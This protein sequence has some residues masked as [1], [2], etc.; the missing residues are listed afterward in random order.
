V[1]N[2]Q[3]LCLHDSFPL[4]GKGQDRLRF[5]YGVFLLNKDIEQVP[6]HKAHVFFTETRCG[7]NLSNTL[8]ISLVFSLFLL[9][10]LVDEFP[11]TSVYG[12]EANAS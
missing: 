9:C 7:Q 11:G 10:S 3:H 5:E 1:S 6:A 12:L 8:N 2:V 4:Y